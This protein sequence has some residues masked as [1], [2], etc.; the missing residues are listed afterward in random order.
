MIKVLLYDDSYPVPQDI[1]SLLGVNR[2]SDIYYRKRSLDRWI[3]DI[4]KAADIQ[5]VQLG[6]RGALDRLSRAHGPGTKHQVVM[7][8]PSFI[9]FG[10]PE[11]DAATFLRKLSLTRSS[12]SV[13]ST[14]AQDT[15]R[16]HIAVAVGDDAESLLQAAEA[17]ASVGDL[18]DGLTEQAHPVD[19]D[20]SM[21]DMRD[22]LHFTDYL[23][24]NFDVR[25]FN[26]VQTVNDFVLIKRSSDADK[27][28][29]EFKYYQLLPPE[30]R[31]FFVQPY[32]FVLEQGHGSY[33]MERLF[34]PDMALQWIHGSLDE[35]GLKR[36]LDKV[37]YYLSIR[38]SRSVDAAV[39]RGVHQEAYREK[40]SARLDQLRSLPQYGA[41]RPYLDTNFGGVDAL[42]KRYVGLLERIGERAIARELRVGHG[43]LCF[44]NIL[45]SKSTG[46]MRFIDPRG[47]E[48]EDDLYVNPYYDLAK[49][50]HSLV[51]NYDFINYGLYRLDVGGDLRVQLTIEPG[52][53][54]WARPLFEAKLRDAGIDPVLIR[55]LEASLFISMVP[56]HIDTPKKVLAFLLN[57]DH[58]LSE[59]E[60][61][62]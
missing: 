9:A 34:V 10:C 58:I 33:K 53:P 48:Q 13:F 30:I 50:S 21:I 19:S 31:M 32:D 39:A 62:L 15:Q 37:F 46:L 60:R 44:S 11:Q 2:Y 38:P 16:P 17:G 14:G 59:I 40:V 43:D 3:A 22:P 29:R 54:Q 24:S 25:F 1:G 8:L 28:H 23:T 45:Y 57:A 61:T 56:L 20:V 27:L 18:L 7:Y 35:L 12:L 26:S 55:L 52:S 36:F 49:L 47:A 42:F 41:L 4:C 5:F 51:G 6:T